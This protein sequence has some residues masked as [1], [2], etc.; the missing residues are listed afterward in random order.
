MP[1]WLDWYYAHGKPLGQCSTVPEHP[2]GQLGPQLDWFQHVWTTVEVLGFALVLYHQGLL[3]WSPPVLRLNVRQIGRRIRDRFFLASPCS[4]SCDQFKWSFGIWAFSSTIMLSF[5]FS[6][7]VLFLTYPDSWELKV[8][9]SSWFNA[10]L[11]FL[12]V[13]LTPAITE[14]G[15]F[16]AIL[17]RLP[18][19]CDKGGR[20]PIIEQ[21]AN[22]FIFM[23]WH[24]DVWHSNPIFRDYRFQLIIMTLGIA[25]QELVIR[26]NVTWPAVFI[27]WCTVWVWLTFGGGFCYFWISAT[28]GGGF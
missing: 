3:E 5:G 1:Q 15:L 14:E 16:R 11:S 24:L 4:L 7:G 8:V 26:I 25:V 20:P 21:V 22:V 9:P 19:E 28:A 12:V 23:V 10:G 2:P 13:W 18:S 6:T 27:H 17:L